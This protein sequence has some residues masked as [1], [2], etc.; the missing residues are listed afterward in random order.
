M[1]KIYNPTKE[2]WSEILLRPTQTV[3][4]IEST[5]GQIFDEVAQ[6]GD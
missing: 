5:V 6:K 3:E 1:N 2:I 4:D